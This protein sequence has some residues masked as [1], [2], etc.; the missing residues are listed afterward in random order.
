VVLDVVAA[1]DVAAI[2][3]PAGNTVAAAA[4][5]AIEMVLRM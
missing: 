3:A 2:K 5:R 4:S 1:A